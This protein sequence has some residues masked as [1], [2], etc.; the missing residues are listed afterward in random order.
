MKWFFLFL[1]TFT[2]YFIVTLILKYFIIK[3]EKISSNTSTLI[4]DLVVDLLKCI[5]K[6]FILFISF[7]ISFSFMNVDVSYN[8]KIDKLLM[9]IC[10]IQLI[11]VAGRLINFWV[12]KFLKIES[13][14]SGEKLASLRFMTIGLKVIVYSIIFLVMLN[15]LGIDVTALI[16]GLGVGGVAVALALQ[17]ILTDLFSSLTIVL[18]KPFV[19]GDFIVINDFMGTVEF[20]GIKT[21]RLR[22]ISGE[23]LIFGNGDL[24]QS[25]IRNYKRMN[26]RRVVQNLTVTYQTSSEMLNE[27]P[28]IVKN[29]VESLDSVRFDRCHFLRFQDSS[30]E[31]ELV[32][33]VESAEF[34]DYADKAHKINVS[35]FQAFSER[36]IEFAYP[37]QTLNLVNQKRDNV[38]FN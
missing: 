33:W 19:V 4:D 8:L 27:I 35:V 23:Q 12:V 21:T 17:N 6:Y 10:A 16:A 28:K 1:G 31:F 15:N 24:L 9:I 11:Q 34:N 37:T 22:S 26:E 30:L 7:Y 38:E 2:L 3:I 32:Y 18:D 36:N 29:I 13:T 25:R 20:I 14:E 5:K